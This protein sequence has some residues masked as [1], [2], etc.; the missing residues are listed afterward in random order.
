MKCSRLLL[1]FGIA[2]FAMPILA[3]VAVASGSDLA[4]AA[5]SPCVPTAQKRCELDVLSPDGIA[6]LKFGA[7]MP[8]ARRV[9]D[10]LLHQGGLPTQRSGSCAVHSEVTWEDQWTANAQ[11]SLTLYFGHRGL[12]G[13]QVGAPQEPRHPPGGWMLATVRGLQVGDILTAARRIYH[14]S[15]KLSASQGGTWRIRSTDGR[16]DGFAWGG[17]RRHTDVGWTSLVASIDAGDVGC[18]A[19]GP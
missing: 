7:S 10:A 8:T 9:M 13:Y 17:A 3:T 15:I 16:L 14:S 6:S 1:A 12:V 19:V 11:P 18:P 2:A 4:H 5:R